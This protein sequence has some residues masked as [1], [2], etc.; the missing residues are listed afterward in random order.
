MN[1]IEIRDLTYHYHKARHAILDRL[2]LTFQPGELH[3]LIG[4]NGAGKTTLFDLLTRLLH[5]NTIIKG[6]PNKQDMVYQVQGMMFPTT[7]TGRDLFRF[8]LHTDYRNEIR[9]GRDPYQDSYMNSN[10]VD[11]MQR[12]WNMRYGD[13]SVGERRYLTLLA[14][15]LMKRSL[16]IFDEPTSNVDPEARVRILNRVQRLA[17]DHEKLVILSTHT[18][19]ELRHYHCRIHALHRGKCTFEGTYSQFLE[20]FGNE[21]PDIAFSH[22]IH[23]H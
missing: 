19:H 22:M 5:T 14:I 10:E 17:E 4:H 21:D 13:M 18:L 6:L 9:V 23:K 16:Y 15:T 1:T 7:L 12:V 3:V 20:H 8:F 2:S 11:F